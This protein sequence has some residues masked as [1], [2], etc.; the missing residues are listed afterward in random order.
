VSIGCRADE[1]RSRTISGNPASEIRSSY[2]LLVR[3]DLGTVS[4]T[5]WCRCR[6]DAFT[7]HVA[8]SHVV[9][10]RRDANRFLAEV[11]PLIGPFRLEEPLKSANKLPLLVLRFPFP[12]GRGCQYT[13]AAKGIEY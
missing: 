12:E 7:T 1:W 11:S 8:D 5:L 9:R 4:T 3:I 10:M 2:Q 6:C 13:N